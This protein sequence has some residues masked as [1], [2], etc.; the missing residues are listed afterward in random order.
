MKSKATKAPSSFVN[1]QYPFHFTFRFAVLWTL[2]MTASR[3]GDPRVQ[4]M[5]LGTG[6]NAHRIADLA[7]PVCKSPRRPAAGAVINLPGAHVGQTRCC[8][9]EGPAHCPWSA[10]PP[11]AAYT[12]TINPSCRPPRTAK[13]CFD[14]YVVTSRS[15]FFHLVTTNNAYKH[16]TH[17]PQH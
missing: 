16:T 15:C 17:I 8:T 4:R 3:F 6:D 2:F 14:N 11:P 5:A 7:V 9:G 13:S 12:A 10:S 1:E